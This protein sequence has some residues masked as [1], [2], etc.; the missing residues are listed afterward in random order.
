M[1]VEEFYIRNESDTEARGPLNFEPIS[2]LAEKGQV[3]AETLC[4]DVG[5][6][7]R[8]AFSSDAT[9]TAKLLP[10]KRHLRVNP[11]VRIV[12]LNQASENAA[13]I[14][15]HDI[16]A[17][18]AGGRGT[19]TRKKVDSAEAAVRHARLGLFAANLAL[20]FSAV[21]LLAPA[22]DLIAKANY[23]GLL[24]HPLTSLGLVDFVRCLLP[25][26][27]PP[28]RLVSFPAEIPVDAFYRR[29]FSSPFLFG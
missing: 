10:R 15:V 3:T 5:Q 19:D 7:Q 17:A 14:E 12:S 28:R 8:V 1:A 9:L 20:L 27:P 11:K 21:A 26:R 16:L 23:I 18:A 24:Q 29:P 4:Y 25:A 6:E 22:V 2:S 13:P